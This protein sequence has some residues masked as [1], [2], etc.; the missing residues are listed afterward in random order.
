L[1]WIPTSPGQYFTDEA[2][3]MR[4]NAMD[5]SKE[6]IQPDQ[7]FIEFRPNEKA[8]MIRGGLGSLRIGQRKLKAKVK[9]SFAYHQ[10]LSATKASL[11]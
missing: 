3:E 5:R 11:F 9:I 2:V 10:M 8:G 6:Y 4:R 1:E 7:K